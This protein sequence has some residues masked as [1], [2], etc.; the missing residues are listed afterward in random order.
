MSLKM[1]AWKWPAWNT[2]LTQEGYELNL[3]T[4]APAEVRRMLARDI[5]RKFWADW[6]ADDPDKQQLLPRPFFEPIR[7]ALRSREKHSGLADHHKN[8]IRG[9]VASGA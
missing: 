5:E 9:I 3:E 1:A 2:F 8:I 6:A 7:A 4:L